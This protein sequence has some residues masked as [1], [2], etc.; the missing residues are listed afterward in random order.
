MTQYRPATDIGAQA[1]FDTEPLFGTA[2][3]SMG[4]TIYLV[5]LDAATANGTNP[6]SVTSGEDSLILSVPD[7]GMYLDLFH[8]GRLVT[9]GATVR[10]IGAVP[11][12]NRNPEVR[13]WPHDIDAAY[14]D[15]EVLWVP[16]PN[17][18]GDPTTILSATGIGTD[19]FVGDPTSFFLA[20]VTHVRVL[21]TSG[22]TPNGGGT[23]TLFGIGARL[24]S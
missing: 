21:V 10:V 19:P 18:S 7:S 14:T 4:T 1:S 6:Y 15:R 3:S 12:P 2:L 16:L 9:T 23:G 17:R 5:H 8:L 22:G 13:R 11:S 24:V 20:G